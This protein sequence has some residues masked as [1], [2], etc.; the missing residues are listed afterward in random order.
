M[1]RV[2]LLRVVFLSLRARAM[3]LASH[4]DGDRR[5]LRAIAA[6]ARRIDREGVLY[7]Q[8]EAAMLRAAVAHLQGDRA[9][10]IALLA[11]ADELSARSGLG[12]SN[13]AVRRARGVLLGG[14]EGAALIAEADA[15]CVG[16]GL[17]RPEGVAAVFAPGFA[18]GAT[19]RALPPP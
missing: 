17:R 19:M 5:R 14:A 1:L 13:L 15:I 12:L 8:S 4:Q 16:Q 9:A 18:P 6:I 11:R 3:I 7:C 10:A 2:Q